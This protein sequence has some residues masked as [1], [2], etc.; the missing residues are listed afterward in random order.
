MRVRGDIVDFISIPCPVAM[1]IPAAGH[2]GMPA[3]E[4]RIDPAFLAGRTCFVKVAPCYKNT[5]PEVRAAAF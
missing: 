3:P 5:Y 2:M 1:N 4:R